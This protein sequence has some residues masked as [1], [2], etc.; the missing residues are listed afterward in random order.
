MEMRAVFESKEAA[1]RSWR[2]FPAGSNGEY[3]LPQELSVVLR[4]GDGCRVQDVTGR[5]F[6][7]FTMG[8]GLDPARPWPLWRDRRSD[9][10][11]PAGLEFCQCE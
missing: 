9:G 7:D 6:L 10:P 1:D 4:R 8:V 2:V 11:G 5:E 3:G